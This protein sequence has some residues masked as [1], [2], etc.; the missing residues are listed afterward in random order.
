MLIEGIV[1]S[2]VSS[3]LWS[4]IDSCCVHS[5]QDEEARLR[6][7]QE[8]V[9]KT[10]QVEL[11]RQRIIEREILEQQLKEQGLADA[12]IVA[13]ARRKLLMA[14]KIQ[15]RR[16]SYSVTNGDCHYSMAGDDDTFRSIQRRR[17]SRTIVP[18]SSMNSRV[19]SAPVWCVRDYDVRSGSSASVVSSL[20]DEE[21]G[22]DD[23]VE[24]IP[25][26]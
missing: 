17:S 16:Q 25:L 22:D 24:E 5:A 21:E 12:A 13:E 6:Q 20:F 26:R 2:I 8:F 11:E 7:H 4:G 10:M 23:D 3:A 9:R 1:S 15:A 19:S 18:P 14:T